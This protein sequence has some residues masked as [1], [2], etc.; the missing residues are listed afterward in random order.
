MPAMRALTTTRTRAMDRF[1]LLTLLSVLLLTAVP[2]VGPGAHATA[3]AAAKGR[4]HPK[5]SPTPPPTPVPAPGVPGGPPHPPRILPP[6]PCAPFRRAGAA[7]AISTTHAAPVG[8]RWRRT[9]QPLI[10]PHRRYLLDMR[11][12]LPDQKGRT[13][14]PAG[15]VTLQLDPLHNPR[16]V[17]AFLFLAC[18]GYYRDATF[19]RLVS[20]S[21]VEGASPSGVARGGPGFVLPTDP[22]RASY[23]RGVVALVD[24]GPDAAAGR[25]LILLATLVLPPR[26]TIFAR[27]VG[28]LDLVDSLSRAPTTNQPDAQEPSMPLRPARIL[29]IELRIM[30]PR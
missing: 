22:V 1:A 4:T 21:L 26:Y 16:T 18:N 11:I 10:N 15:V 5:P 29:S 7:L 20:G 13:L 12:G 28:G 9:P 30:A 6:D 27:V 25:F 23:R 2:L 8:F 19:D 17:N 14:R 3:T 24:S